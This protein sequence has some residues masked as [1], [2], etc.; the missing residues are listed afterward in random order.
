MGQ[1]PEMWTF[2]VPALPRKRNVNVRGSPETTARPWTTHRTKA[3]KGGHNSISKMHNRGNWIC[4]GMLDLQT[5]GKDIQVHWGELQVLIP[6]GPGAL[7]GDP[8]RKE[9]TSHGG[10]FPGS[11]PRDHTGGAVS[12]PC[13]LPNSPPEASVGVSGD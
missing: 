1:G 10:P 5:P 9:N 11:T 6:K 13:H 2:R 8:S 3:L 7:E 4:S 12:D